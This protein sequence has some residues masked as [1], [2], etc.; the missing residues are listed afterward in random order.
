M[1]P[2]ND[3]NNLNESDPDFDPDVAEMMR[4]LTEA[5][6]TGESDEK[7]AEDEEI[8]ADDEGGDEPDDDE[9]PDDE[10][11]PADPEVTL[12][13]GTTLTHSKISELAAFSKFLESNPEAAAAVA[14]GNQALSFQPPANQQALI[15]AA[16]VEDK[17]PEWLETY[18]ELRDFY[19]QSQTQAKMLEYQRQELLRR[20]QIDM[21]A[22]VERAVTDWNARYK[23]SDADIQKVRARAAELPTASTLIAQGR[24]AYD[25]VTDALESAFWTIPEL[26]NQALTAQSADT[27]RRDR[28]KKRK[29]SA[30]GGKNQAPGNRTPQPLTKEQRNDAV[31]AELSAA[32]NER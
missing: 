20:E 26:R 23:L 5:Y 32:M 25:S 3:L 21:S 16:P 24:P 2:T 22:N 15:P 31:I 9:T 6:N 19:N 18:P 8:P 17:D 13:D 11:I 7:P 30:L 28:A 4:Q 27:Q 10:E 29:L 12:P 1:P 14:R